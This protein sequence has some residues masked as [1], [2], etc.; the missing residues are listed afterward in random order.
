M[1]LPA[2]L[3]VHDGPSVRLEPTH[4]NVQPSPALPA[5][6]P[7][8][9]CPSP[10]PLPGG[11]SFPPTDPTMSCG[12][13]N[14]ICL[15]GVE[16][17]GPVVQGTLRYTCPGRPSGS[18]EPIRTSPPPRPLRPPLNAVGSGCGGG[19]VALDSRGVTTAKLQ[20][21]RRPGSGGGGGG[22]GDW[23]GSGG[24]SSLGKV[25]RSRP[26][27]A[28]PGSYAP[29]LPPQPSPLLWRR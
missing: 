12:A 2:H 16:G 10:P 5:C 9:F 7:A 1:P 8:S 14:F 6:L 18:A 13:Y 15:G 20:R 11:V 17:R 3:P 22:G 25:S 27:A 28:P 19:G 4:K 26:A 21:R 24:G 23:S 29:A